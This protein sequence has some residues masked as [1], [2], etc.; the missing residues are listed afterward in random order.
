M[1]IQK[2]RNLLAEGY[3]LHA[4]DLFSPEGSIFV[5]DLEVYN[6]VRNDSCK[7]NRKRPLTFCDFDRAWRYRKFVAEAKMRQKLEKLITS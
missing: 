6:R 2:V 4:G 3:C 5:I 7:T 1:N